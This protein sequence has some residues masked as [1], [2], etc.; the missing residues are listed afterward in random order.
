MQ[1][2]AALRRPSLSIALLIVGG[3]LVAAR[4][5]EHPG[6]LID[7]SSVARLRHSCGV[8]Q[9]ADASLD[10]GRFGARA[11]DFQALRSCF[12]GQMG[13]DVLPGELP[14]MAF[15]HLIDPLDRADGDRLRLINTQLEHPPLSTIDLVELVLALDWCWDDLDPA[16]RR[17]FLLTVRKRL[18]P[19]TP[20]DSP[21]EPRRFRDRL[22]ALALAVAVD[23][24][25][26]PSPSWLELREQL[27]VA[28]REYFR[29]TFPVFVEWRGLCPT[30]PTAGPR[31]ECDTA[32]AI[33]IAGHVLGQEQ[34]PQYTPTVGRWL[35]HY[36]LAALAHPALQSNFIREDG[37][38]A[39]LSPA[40][41]PDALLPI[42]AHLIATRTGDPSAALL[43][44]RVEAD[45]HGSS[46]LALPTVWRWVP[47]VFDISAIAR[48][49]VERLPTARD[50]GGAVILRG[51]SRP[52]A[53]AI[54]V[55]T[56]GAFLRRRQHFDA[57]HFLI[58]R[59]G[60][61]TV[62]GGEGVAFE[63]VPSK[64]GSQH[65]G[66]ERQ[67]FDF[68]QYFT[69]TIAHNC[70][71]MWDPVTLTRWYGKRYRPVGGQRCIENTCHDFVS[72]P[73]AQGR[74]TGTRIAYGQRDG[75]AYL[76]L[77]L[78]PAYERDVLSAYTREFVFLLDRVLVVVDRV[79]P[80]KTRAQP[81]WVLNIPARP[82]VEGSDLQDA[83]RIAGPTND[84]GVWDYSSADW[85][86]WT[87]RDGALWMKSLL[88]APR[89][90][91]VVGGPARN[92][93][94]PSGPHADRRYTG[95]AADGY[96]HLIVP[97]TRRETLNAWYRLE[98]PTLLG[99]TF[100]QRPHW[101]RIEIEPAATTLPST[102]V[103]ILVTDVASS[104]TSPEARITPAGD[105]LAVHLAVDGRRAVLRVPA[106]GAIGGVL[107]IEGGASW[108]LP[109][110]V[111][112]DQRLATE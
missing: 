47:I 41:S 5:G 92:L 35:E 9:L 70:L 102:F 58:R 46:S 66:D 109:T 11:A 23:E 107:D 25:D 2:P 90:L 95:G 104:E 48:C 32:L 72:T 33:E 60:C 100:G 22:A 63:A 103:T 50:L 94:V 65:L 45:L 71:L 7:S 56:G 98:A 26:E 19:L 62:A 112:P 73:V 44:G 106:T 52:H 18:K 89:A 80:G 43:A 67:D 15:L 57:G 39:P 111:Q 53:T 99:Q 8:G 40:A 96:E 54:W 64:G 93:L 97:A 36:V 87:D 88:P 110:K 61:L 74:Q 37:T 85:L 101:G 29:T 82:Q 86:R 4:G 20:A 31:E 55:D 13:T 84:A 28:G 27:L 10:W 81:T 34:W 69:S 42:T 77:D 12:A 6:L 49:A 108:T 76:A 14:A 91:R 78:A 1:I 59:G 68:E 16:A 51:R 24:R 3:C 30:S 75:A 38:S 21:L 83:A 79:V 17:E 105:A